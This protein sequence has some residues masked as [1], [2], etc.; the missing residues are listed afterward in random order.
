ML[1]PHSKTK[2]FALAR[3]KIKSNGKLASSK[4]SF[5]DEEVI[6]QL[7]TIAHVNLVSMFELFRIVL[8]VGLISDATIKMY[9]GSWKHKCKS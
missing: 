7:G 2:A 6:K 5:V 4:G 8:Y 3:L 1:A 9:R